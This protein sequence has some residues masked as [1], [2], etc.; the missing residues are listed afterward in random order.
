M[1]SIKSNE[2]TIPIGQKMIPFKCGKKYK[3]NKHS[4]NHNNNNNNNLCVLQNATM[5]SEIEQCF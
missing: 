4:Y 5:P 2:N 3:Q 1:F